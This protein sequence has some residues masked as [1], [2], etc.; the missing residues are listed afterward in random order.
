[1]ATTCGVVT[2]ALA[3]LTLGLRRRGLEGRLNGAE[4][5]LLK[6]LTADEAHDQAHAK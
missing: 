6:K 2:T 3:G 1:M 5:I 4:G